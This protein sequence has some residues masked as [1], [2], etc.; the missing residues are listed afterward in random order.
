MILRYCKQLLGQENNYLSLVWVTVN[1]IFHS[2]KHKFDIAFLLCL[3]FNVRTQTIRAYPSHK[4]FGIQF[5]F[6]CALLHVQDG[7]EIIK[8]DIRWD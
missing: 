7:D 1:R 2:T 3:Q 4:P 8:I 6:R 5:L